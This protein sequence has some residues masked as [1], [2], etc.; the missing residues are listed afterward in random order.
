MNCESQLTPL[1]VDNYFFKVF[2]KRL[3]D[4][5]TR[6][7]LQSTAMDAHVSPSASRFW[8]NFQPE[9]PSVGAFDL[10]TT[11]ASAPLRYCCFY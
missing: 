4:L 11:V 7:R 6:N 8:R 9:G 3:R 5:R 1:P 10:P 2:T